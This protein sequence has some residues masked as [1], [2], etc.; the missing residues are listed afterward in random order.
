MEIVRFVILLK[1]NFIRLMKLHDF[2]DF[3][4]VCSC[5]DTIIYFLIVPCTLRP[6]ISIT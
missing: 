1:E 6:A 3:I 2:V 4:S 5:E